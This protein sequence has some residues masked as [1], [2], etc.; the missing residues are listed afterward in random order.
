M[1]W[2]E[3][4]KG[5]LSRT[6]VRDSFLVRDY[7]IKVRTQKQLFTP[8]GKVPS[9]VRVMKLGFAYRKASFPPLRQ[10]EESLHEKQDFLACS[11]LLL[12]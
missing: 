11:L 1:Y 9:F 12:V 6:L 3:F 10:C 8:T 7:L 5:N 4:C 2:L